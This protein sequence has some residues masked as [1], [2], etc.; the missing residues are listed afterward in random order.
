MG[1][2]LKHVVMVHCSGTFVVWKHI[3]KT[4]VDNVLT[5]HLPDNLSCSLAHLHF[6]TKTTENHLY[7][8]LIKGGLGH[9]LQINNQQRLISTFWP[10]RGS[11]TQLPLGEIRNKKSKGNEQMSQHERCWES[12]AWGLGHSVKSV[13][14]SACSTPSLRVAVMR[15]HSREE[16]RWLPRTDNRGFC[17]QLDRGEGWV[18]A[19]VWVWQEK[20]TPLQKKKGFHWSVNMSHVRREQLVTPKVEVKPKH[21]GFFTTPPDLVSMLTKT[22]L[23]SYVQE[24]DLRGQRLNYL[25]QNLSLL[26]SHV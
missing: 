13:S 5:R 7:L 8:T 15:S 10:H 9:N 24:L 25:I 6:L 19:D 22:S 12:R 17:R 2:I 14:H 3:L 20:M 21:C 23:H 18:S 1:V 16:A 26:S 11:S 4:Y